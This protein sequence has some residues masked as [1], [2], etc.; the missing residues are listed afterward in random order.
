MQ[1]SYWEK[2]R[3]FSDIDVL[4][5][6]SGIVGLNAALQLKQTAPSLRVMVIERGILPSGASTKNAGFACFGSC[7]ELID[8][9]GNHSEDE[10]FALVEK[11]YRGL[12]RLRSNL[13][14]RAI[15]FEQLGGYEVFDEDKTYQ[16]CLAHI[17][18]FNRRMQ[19]ITGNPETYRRADEAIAGFGFKGVRHLLLNT[20]EGQIDTGR[21]MAALIEKTQT[22]GVR[23]IN[24]LGI[25]SFASES[26]GVTVQT[27]QDF[28][29][30]ARKLL[31]CTNGFARQ[32]LPEYDVDPAR[33]QVLI[34]SPIE[35]LKVRGTFHYEKGY[36]YFRNVGNRILFGGGRNLDFSGEK[37]TD[38]QLTPVIQNKLEQLLEE[39]IL[40]GVSYSIE[41]RWSGIMGV[42]GR[43]SSIVKP[44]QENIFCAVR[45]GGMGVA[46][47]S[48]VGEEAAAM[49]VQT[50]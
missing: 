6:G 35:G 18:P 2:D 16:E 27:D 7:T 30:S 40:P 44:V 5:I 10:V 32:L 14:D 23:I 19:R 4:V 45:M 17:D 46:I 12:Q 28:T 8:D 31:I 42:G 38:M 1:L 25:V 9:L 20:E 50:L 24:G 22:A 15:A 49:V 26:R 34:T 41:Q 13:G 39:L 21:M 47:G 43:K 37:T 3:F 33:A 36:Y 48:L 29:I 11:R